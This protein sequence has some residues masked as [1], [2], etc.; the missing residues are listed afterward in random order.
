MDMREDPFGSMAFGKAALEKIKP[1]D[2]NFYLYEAGW[3]S[4]DTMEVNG[5]VFREAKSGPNKGKLVMLVKGSEKKAF[6]TAEEMRK[7]K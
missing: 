4:D 1:T 7:F 5:A 3:V 6:V 2:P